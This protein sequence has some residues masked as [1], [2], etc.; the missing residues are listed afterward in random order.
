[1]VV[2]TAH[3]C[4]SLILTNIYSHHFNQIFQLLRILHLF[5]LMT[6]QPEL[7]DVGGSCSFVFVFHSNSSL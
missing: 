4:A 3:Y 2:V 1:M 5:Y 7:F 6:L